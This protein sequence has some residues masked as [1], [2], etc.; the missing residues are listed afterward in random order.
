M[1]P[2]VTTTYLDEQLAADLTAPAPATVVGVPQASRTNNGSLLSDGTVQSAT[3]RQFHH[4]P[5]GFTTAR[6]LFM[7]A[8]GS[9]GPASTITVKASIETGNF[10]A[11]PTGATTSCTPVL[12]GG[13]NSVVL[14][15]GEFA[16]SDPVAK[17][18][19]VN[20]IFCTRSYVAAGTLGQRW[21]VAQQPGVAVYAAT[22]AYPWGYDASVDKT[23]GGATTSPAAS[24]MTPFCPTAVLGLAAGATPFVAVIGDSIADGT[25][26]DTSANDPYGFADWS[27]QHAAFGY[28][29]LAVS[30]LAANGWPASAIGS[31]ALALMNFMGVTHAVNELGVNDLTGTPPTLLTMQGRLQSIWAS[32]RAAGVGKVYQTT[33]TPIT[34]SSDNWAT[35]V[36]QTPYA[37][38]S[39]RV[40]L[41]NWIRTVPAGLDGFFEM[42]DVCESSHNSGKWVVNGT[43]FYATAEG[44]HPNGPLLTTPMGA[45]MPAGTFTL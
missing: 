35:L 25:G 40:V 33:I 8:T 16:L 32:F 20:G 29:R 7:N 43:P 45:A 39:I 36:N 14:A 26:E 2:I 13:V 31:Q 21:P 37:A 15:P 3:Y 11:D 22:A 41:N 30:G 5:A 6:L 44:I 18:V 10:A 4:S 1:S 42:A 9:A 23:A 17:T 34:T 19:G 12:F 38:E 24:S 27:S 28:M